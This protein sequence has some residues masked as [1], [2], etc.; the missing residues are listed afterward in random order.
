MHI[1]IIMHNAKICG[2]RQ[3]TKAQILPSITEV[4]VA[5]RSQFLFS[6]PFTSLPLLSFFPNRSMMAHRLY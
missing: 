6:V 4:M 3:R 2:R 1:D 5:K